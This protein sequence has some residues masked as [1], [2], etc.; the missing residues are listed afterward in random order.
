MNEKIENQE[1]KFKCVMCKRIGKFIT[2][3]D[4]LVIVYYIAP[5]TNEILCSSC[6]SINN[7]IAKGKGDARVGKE[8]IFILK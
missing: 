2:P 8:E 7:L 3:R 1:S 5:Q 6:N 4:K